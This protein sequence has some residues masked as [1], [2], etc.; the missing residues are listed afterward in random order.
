MST[1]PVCLF[2]S[3]LSHLRYV[4]RTRGKQHSRL[5]L[6]I[7]NISLINSSH[8]HLSIHNQQ[9][10]P[11][12]ASALQNYRAQH[13]QSKNSVC[14]SFTNTMQI[15]IW[16]DANCFE[17]WNMKPHEHSIVIMKMHSIQTKLKPRPR[18]A[19]MLF[20]LSNLVIHHCIVMS[21]SH[22]ISLG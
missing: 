7:L 9:K 21:G 4:Q 15:S 2:Q 5:N 6:K 22:R 1:F 12:N 13:V 18:T 19:M 17:D 3:V 8:F 20:I 10:R 11:S 16:V 14:F